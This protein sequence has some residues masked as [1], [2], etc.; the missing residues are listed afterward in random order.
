MRSHKSTVVFSIIIHVDKVSSRFKFFG[1]IFAYRLVPENTLIVP[2]RE[3]NI[4]SS[5]YLSKKFYR[6]KLLK[7]SKNYS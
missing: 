1:E 6:T 4:L 5:A 3:S 2:G 7:N